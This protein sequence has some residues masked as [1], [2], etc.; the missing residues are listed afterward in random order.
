MQLM[1]VVRQDGYGAHK[2]GE[3]CYCYPDTSRVG[4][5]KAEFDDESVRFFCDE[6]VR[7]AFDAS[8]P[9]HPESAARPSA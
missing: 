9:Q 4:V 3:H 7:D 8:Q 5:W 1:S 2:R 6:H